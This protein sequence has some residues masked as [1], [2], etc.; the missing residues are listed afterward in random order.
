MTG[1]NIDTFSARERVVVFFSITQKIRN[2]YRFRA[3]KQLSPKT[4]VSRSQYDVGVPP[5]R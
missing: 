2:S 4:Y 1:K 5:A 3:E